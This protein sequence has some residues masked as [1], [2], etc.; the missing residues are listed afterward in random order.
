MHPSDNRYKVNEVLGED[1]WIE[2]AFARFRQ[3]EHT[4]G[5]HDF[6]LPASDHAVAPLQHATD[7]PNFG[8]ML[9]ETRHRLH[10]HPIHAGISETTGDHSKDVLVG[11]VRNAYHEGC[12]GG[13][14]RRVTLDVSCS[15]PADWSSA[16]INGLGVASHYYSKNKHD[17]KEY[18]FEHFYRHGGNDRSNEGDDNHSS[19][20]T[21]AIDRVARPASSDHRAGPNMAMPTTVFVT[22]QDVMCGRGDATNCHPGNV[23]FREHK[24]E[25]MAQFDEETRAEQRAVLTES[26]QRIHVQNGDFMAKDERGWYVVSHRAVRIDWNVSSHVYCQDNLD[27]SDRYYRDFTDA[28]VLCGGLVHGHHGT[29]AFRAARPVREF[30]QSAKRRKSLIKHAMVER[31][32]ANGGRFLKRHEHGLGHWYEITH[33]DALRKASQQTRESPEQG[34]TKRARLKERRQ[35]STANC[36]AVYDSIY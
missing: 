5:K 11:A 32:H 36:L 20:D 19:D 24:A 28:D 6:Q 2:V 23:A 12:D 1:D 16:N 30:V 3:P 26:V 15:A 27:P 18:G 33:K 17:G 13:Q 10:L 14:S 22:D 35:Y 21:L 34:R 9:H 31:V 25:L 8:G 4:S 7:G 29:D